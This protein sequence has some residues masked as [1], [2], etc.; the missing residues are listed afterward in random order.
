M[1]KKWL[2]GILCDSLIA[3]VIKTCCETTI[4]N[5][6]STTN[7]MDI[8]IDIIWEIVVDYVHYVLDVKAPG[9]DI[10][11]DQN[12]SFS[13]AEGNHCVLEVNNGPENS[14]KNMRLQIGDLGRGRWGIWRC[15]LKEMES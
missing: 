9:S 12:G 11:G 3:T 7:S 4:A 15:G 14:P 2:G 13:V 6:A 8:F 1:W 10:C 5:T